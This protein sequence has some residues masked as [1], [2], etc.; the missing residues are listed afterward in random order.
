[1]SYGATP[2]ARGGDAPLHIDDEDA[3]FGR[4]REDGVRV[5]PRALIGA[6]AVAC[7]GALAAHEVGRSRGTKAGLGLCSC[8]CHC[9]SDGGGDGGETDEPALSVVRGAVGNMPKTF[10]DQEV[11]DPI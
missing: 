10:L 9:D 4:R 1:M 5:S 3:S 8:E 11:T 2:G 6:I 7:A